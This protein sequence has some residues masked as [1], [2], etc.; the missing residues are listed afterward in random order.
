MGARAPR[1]FDFDRGLPQI[2]QQFEI[3]GSALV[4]LAL[5]LQELK[6]LDEKF[7]MD[8]VREVGYYAAVH[9]QK[10]Y[11]GV[12]ILSRFP[13]HT[14][15][16]MGFC[17]RA[18]ARHISAVLGPEAGQAAGLALHNFYIPAGGDVPE[19]RQRLKVPIRVYGAMLWLWLASRQMFSPNPS[20]ARRME[21]LRRTMP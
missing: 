13:L 10:T 20:Q 9:G 8:E 11:N 21:K 18:D 5:C 12:A 4:V 2:A 15:D 6:C 14:R 1:G 7:P 16:V 3:E 19:L 17:G